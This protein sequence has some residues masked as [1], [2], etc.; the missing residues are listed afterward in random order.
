M[1]SFW[2]RIVLWSATAC[3]AAASALPPKE[4]LPDLR[5]TVEQPASERLL[6]AASLHPR[7]S[8]AEHPR[9]AQ[10]GCE[11]VEVHVTL[12]REMFGPDVVASVTTAELRQL[13]EGIRFVEAMRRHPL[14]KARL[15]ESVTS[16]RGIFMKSVVAARDLAA[17]TVLAAEHLGSKKPG[18]GIPANE[19][20]KLVGRRVRRDVARDALIAWDDLEG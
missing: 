15:P 2:T 10:V 19:L 11:L 20:P 12:S 3:A 14:D 6:K 5:P 9:A 13:V 1:I 16:L 18:S 4:P 7:A 8:L 17:G